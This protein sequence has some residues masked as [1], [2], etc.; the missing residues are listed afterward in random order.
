MEEVI[1]T[2]T[3]KWSLLR[4]YLLLKAAARIIREV[5]LFDVYQ[6]DSPA[7]IIEDCCGEV[8]AL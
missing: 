8:F 3:S 1:C 2:N 5:A 7:T 6:Q 4:I